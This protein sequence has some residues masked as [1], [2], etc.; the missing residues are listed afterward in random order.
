MRRPMIGILVV[1]G[2]ISIVGVAFLGYRIVQAQAESTT[3]SPPTVPVSCGDVQQTISAPGL[4]VSVKEIYLG[5]GASGSLS[6]IY[7]KPGDSVEAG[8]LLAQLNNEDELIAAVEDARAEL[9]T[10]QMALDELINNAPLVT[11]QTRLDLANAHDELRIAKYK[12]WVLQEGH[13]A[14]SETIAAAKAEVALAMEGVRNAEKA[15]NAVAGLPE[16]NPSRAY[17]RLQLAEART[18]RDQALAK[19]NWYLGHPTELQQ[20]ILDAEVAVAEANL[21]V[22]EQTWERVKDGPDPAKLA[23]L[24]A[25]VS[26]A[27]TQLT[28]AQADLAGLELRAPFD[29]VIMD[30]NAKVGDTIA[31]N[32]DFIL[33]SDLSSLEVMVTVI[34]EDLP[35]IEVGQFVDLYF[36]ARPDVQGIGEV[37]RVVPKRLSGDRPL[38]AVYISIDEL[39]EGLAPGMTVDAS[40]I[41]SRQEDVLRI[42]KALIRARSDRTAKVEVW[43]N[44]LREE[45]TVQVGLRGDSYVEILSGL[46]EGDQV[47]GE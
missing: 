36:D 42:P 40:I 22:A 11:A 23:E 20:I 25:Q 7:V 1:I 15:L 2:L 18:R 21:V 37:E 44:G 19:M 5:M 34:E 30:I 3:E 46:I 43:L 24:E 16:D 45:R 12:N 29:G 27:E 17:A 35:Q 33:L 32:S 10:A 31:A 38:Y 39:P 4:L 26:R 14:S 13:R 47:I 6:E 41:L 9:A 28:K 8:Q